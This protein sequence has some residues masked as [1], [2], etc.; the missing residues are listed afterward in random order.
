M[1][2]DDLYTASEQ[3]IIDELDK[4]VAAGGKGSLPVKPKDIVDGLTPWPRR[5]SK[6][7]LRVDGFDV[8]CARTKNDTDPDSPYFVFVT[9]D[10]RVLWPPNGV[11]VC[12]HCSAEP[13]VDDGDGKSTPKPRNGHGFGDTPSKI[14][15]LPYHGKRCVVV[16]LYR[17]YK[18]L[19]CGKTY[20][21]QWPDFSGSN[22]QFS[23]R[24]VSAIR[25]AS[26]SKR[27]FETVA[28]DYAVDD[29]TVRKYF[30]EEVEYRKKEL[31]FKTPKHIGIDES[32]VHTKDG[33]HFYVAILDTGPEPEHNGI[34]EMDTV[35]RNS[36]TIAAIF[37]R[38]ENPSAVETISMDMCGAYRVAAEDAL[39][40]ARIIVDRFHLVK[41]LND[42][43][44]DTASLLYKH[45]KD[46]MEKELK[47]A[48]TPA[49]FDPALTD[50]S[51]DEDIISEKTEKEAEVFFTFEG[52]ATVVVPDTLPR[53]EYLQ[54]RLTI[55]KEGYHHR[56]F[57][58]NPDNMSDISKVHMRRLLE[59]FPEFKNLFDIKELMRFH[60]F[61][62]K[63]ADT[64]RRIADIAWNKIPTERG[65]SGI[66]APLKKYFDTL[67]D[68]EW[69]PHIYAYFEDPISSPAYFD[70]DT[71]ELISP[72]LRDKAGVPKP[73]LNKRYSNAK[74]EGFNKIVKEI[75]AASRGLSW[76]ELKAKLLLG[77]LSIRHRPRSYKR[78][79]KA[80]VALCMPL[81]KS[82]LEN[83]D[84]PH[85]I[86]PRRNDWEAIF[87][88]PV[89][90]T[91]LQKNW[92]HYSSDLDTEE[93]IELVE[94]NGNFRGA[95]QGL[96]SNEDRIYASILDDDDADGYNEPYGPPII[97][98]LRFSDWEENKDK[99]LAMI[100]SDVQFLD[101]LNNQ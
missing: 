79:K 36:E 3:S 16:V 17:R 88:I 2:C 85:R 41:S 10:E 94:S 95:L 9:P 81:V 37:R 28:Y 57:T 74:L 59:N 26:M 96:L 71:G 24:L 21:V 93:L 69:T 80:A 43:V 67:N 44:A 5:A 15:D 97:Q 66:Y 46:E 7:F 47:I 27:T 18:C 84:F 70:K 82:Y 72:I 49:E 38:F 35:R 6:E 34:I 13:P 29:E 90:Q 19:S 22:M 50:I 63:D 53:D 92:S 83:F 42:K 4:W 8:L 86:T 62:A 76:E 32:K 68:S 61:H 100:A 14:R 98:P 60:F 77:D 78:E 30:R 91:A 11:P 89:V 75:N 25:D 39:K 40:G 87:S 65:K 52:K 58:M 51:E 23:N 48:P 73:R 55:L 12:P 45:L 64:A 56:R 33:S 99:Y 1:G 54:R 101:R 20:R 31:K